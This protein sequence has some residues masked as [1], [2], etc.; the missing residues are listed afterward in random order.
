MRLSPSFVLLATSSTLVV[1]SV[2]PV[3]LEK[4]VH[5]DRS[6]PIWIDVDC[7]G[8]EALCNADCYAILCLSSPN[9]T[10]YEAGSGDEKRKVSGYKQ[11]LLTTTEKTRKEKGINIPQNVLA[12]VGTSVE[13]ANMAN[14]AQGGEGEIL[15]AANADENSL[16]GRN[17]GAQLTRHV[18][19]GSWYFRWFINYGMGAP[20][21]YALQ[22]GIS[23]SHTTV[24]AAGVKGDTTICTTKDKKPTDPV[25]LAFTKEAKDQGGKPHYH[26]MDRNAGDRWI[27]KLWGLQGSF[28]KNKER[29]VENKEDTSALVEVEK[30]E[31]DVVA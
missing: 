16:I 11:G 9:P 3:Q 14:T 15:F 28:P 30:K 6:D 2:I 8:G 22:G 27:G 20:Y 5:G 1:A 31:V 18:P 23:K 19:D 12:Q 4:R 7:V 10:Q 29:N 21:C 24:P 26:M 17:V 13:E 25:F